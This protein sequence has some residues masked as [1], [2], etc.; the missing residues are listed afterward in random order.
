LDRILVNAAADRSTSDV[1]KGF[2]VSDTDRAYR[3]IS[4][5]FG[6][7]PINGT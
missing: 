5:H 4:E 3:R 6:P 7:R 1:A 2:E